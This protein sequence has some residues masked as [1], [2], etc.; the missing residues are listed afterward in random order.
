MIFDHSVS[1]YLEIEGM[2]SPGGG[3]ANCRVSWPSIASTGEP[4][5]IFPATV[6]IALLDR[7]EAQ[8][9]PLTAN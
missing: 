8:A 6:E 5:A 7:P 2:A 4:A 3:V 9:V 1:G